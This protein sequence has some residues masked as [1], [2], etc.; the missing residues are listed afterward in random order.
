MK[1]IIILSCLPLLFLGCFPSVTV[2]ENTPDTPPPVSG[3]MVKYTTFDEFEIE[4]TPPALFEGIS[5][6]EML[7]SSG[8]DIELSAL[9]TLRDSITSINS[10]IIIENEKGK[11]WT[12]SV[13]FP[14]SGEYELMLMGKYLSSTENSYS[15]I[16]QM[17]FIAEVENDGTI[18]FLNRN[19]F[20]NMQM[21][22]IDDVADVTDGKWIAS[23]NSWYTYTE[24]K[25]GVF[26]ENTEIIVH[27]AILTVSRGTALKFLD[28]KREIG[29]FAFI[30]ENNIE[31]I[32][33]NHTIPFKGGTEIFLE[34]SNT[35]GYTAE[36]LTF[37][38]GGN[39]F[40]IPESSLLIIEEGNIRKIDIAGVGEI[41]IGSRSYLAEGTVSIWDYIDMD[42]TNLS[43][44]TV[45]D[46]S[47]SQGNFTLTAPAGSDI[48]FQKS[49]VSMIYFSEKGEIMVDGKP[50]TVEESY[51]VFFD[52]DGNF[53][54]IS[55]Y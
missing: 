22:K 20:Q 21:I 5:E 9:L 55:P 25:T 31:M 47:I 53:L 13:F 11:S 4:I 50:K 49:I 27:N 10:V 37:N 48:S 7:V 42:S 34:Y 29:T 3:N 41:T 14:K 54:E 17:N 43:L 40:K 44:Q 45:E 52:E 18:Y 12:V 32:L 15:G 16:V 6:A 24:F 30:L 39:T 2:M 46:T 51:Y 26:A 36:E 28:Y 23:A 33:G 1:K 19:I 8:K 35:I 38:I